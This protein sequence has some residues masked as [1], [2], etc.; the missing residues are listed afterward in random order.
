MEDNVWKMREI[1]RKIGMLQRRTDAIVAYL[2]TKIDES[3]VSD[4]LF[5][6]LSSPVEELEW[7]ISNIEKCIED[8]N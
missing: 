2:N 1:V 7:R 8:L 5:R 4:D 6:A 3:D